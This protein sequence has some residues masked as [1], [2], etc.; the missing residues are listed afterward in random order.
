MA[1]LHD[2]VRFA[3]EKPRQLPAWIERI[4]SAGIVTNDPKI[5]R[6]Q[7]FVNM[8][9]YFG[10]LNTAARFVC[11]GLRSALAAAACALRFRGR[12]AW[13]RRTKRSTSLT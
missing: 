1:R 13:P 2:L 9:S 10:S 12:A 4:V 5:A 8:A 11:G 3:G 7:R 6:R